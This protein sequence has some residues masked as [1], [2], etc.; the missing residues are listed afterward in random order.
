LLIMST[1]ISMIANVIRNNMKAI[2]V[3]SE[4]RLYSIRINTNANAM[5][6]ISCM[7]RADR[8]MVYQAFPALLLQL[9]PGFLSQSGQVTSQDP[10]SS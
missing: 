10:F 8:F 6:E 2:K 4:N 5:M 9:R 7:L 3:V 1:Y